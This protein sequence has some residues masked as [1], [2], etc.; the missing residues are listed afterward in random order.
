MERSAA[1]VIAIGLLIGIA[2]GSL[3]W[4]GDSGA[5][6]VIEA[7]SGAGELSP[8]VAA[9]PASEGTVVLPFSPPL[10]TPVRYRWTFT[11]R[12]PNGGGH[13]VES[14][15][16]LRFA[17][18]SGG[19]YRLRWQA[20][21]FSVEAG[22]P[23]RMALVAALEPMRRQ[24]IVLDIS[25]GGRVMGV[26]NLAEMRAIF[27]RSAGGAAAIVDARYPDASPEARA[28]LREMMRAMVKSQQN[29]TDKQFEAVI[30]RNARDLLDDPGPLRPGQPRHAELQLPSDVDG[31]PMDFSVEMLLQGYD[32]GRSADVLATGQASPD[33]VARLVKTMLKPGV[34]AVGDRARRDRMQAAV[35]ALPDASL[36][37]QVM[38][39]L[40]L[41]SGMPVE[42]S[43]ITKLA[44]A[45][46]GDSVEVSTYRRLP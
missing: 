35:D 28:M 12:L 37:L 6:P 21:D 14:V 29:M 16:T 44:V 39:S 26:A 27:T 40:S 45:G 25:P 20:G 38:R 31:T 4:W 2:G 22:E 3:L 1:G 33:D 7:A 11:V 15:D 41:P 17:Q 5:T 9:Q 42:A 13:R 43:R 36:S 24:T 18:A 34:A 8:G 10:D 30:M 46:F 23:Q 32:P 19:G